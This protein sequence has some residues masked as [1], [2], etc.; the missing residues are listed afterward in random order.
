[1]NIGY[2]IRSFLSAETGIGVYFRNL[3]REI[4]ETNREDFFYLFSSSLKERFDRSRLPGGDNYRFKEFRLPVS[5]LNFCW[6]KLGIPPFGFFFGRK[7][8]LVHSPLPII[9]PGKHKNIITVHD[10]CL[11]DHPGLVMKE[12][13][14]YFRDSLAHSLEEA[15]GV[16][17]VSEFTRSRLLAHFGREYAARTRV[18]YHG[19]DLETV[20]ARA[21][22]FPL[23]EKYLLYVGTR[24]PRKNLANLIQALAAVNKRDDSVHLVIAGKKGWDCDEF[25]RVLNGSGMKD[26]VIMPDYVRREELKFLYTNAALL[27]MPSHYE[28]FGLPLL[29]AAYCGLPAACSEI[30][31]FREIFADFPEYFDPKDPGDMAAKICLLL[32]DRRLYEEKKLRAGEI[33]KKRTWAEAA[34]QTEDFYREVC[35]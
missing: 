3:T 16:I 28:G 9:F 6:Y 19:S 22:G 33:G 23:P 7:M 24:E 1:M 11:I 18:I 29:E 5:V 31:V 2:D 27:V 32:E 4:I 10:L 14:R 25:L 34:R 30:P 26:R 17:V 13:T 20:T 21:P 8:D 15:D 35:Q 12:A